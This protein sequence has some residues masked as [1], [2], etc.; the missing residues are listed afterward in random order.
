MNDPARRDQIQQLFSESLFYATAGDDPAW[1]RVRLRDRKT[2]R[3][4]DLKN[5]RMDLWFAPSPNNSLITAR[6]VNTGEI[7]ALDW[8][9]P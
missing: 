6:S 3:V 2:E 1:W 9:A 7:H 4:R 8:E 5:M